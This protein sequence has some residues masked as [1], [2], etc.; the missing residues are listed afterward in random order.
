MAKFRDFEERMERFDEVMSR[1]PMLQPISDI[2]REGRAGRDVRRRRAQRKAQRIGQKAMRMAL[3]V[4]AVLVGSV[5]WGV[6]VGPIGI[7][8]FMAVILA[9]ICLLIALGTYPRDTAPEP[10]KLATA[11]PAVL[12][13]QVDAW[14]DAKRRSL[15][16]LAAPKVDAISAQLAALG[17]QLAAVPAGDPTALELNRLLGKHLPE[18]VDRYEK[19]SPAQR[20][21]ATVPGGPTIERQLVDG[22]GLIEAELVRVNERLGAEDRDAFLVQGK[23]LENRYGKDGTL[24]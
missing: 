15:P 10:V 16:L 23:F 24:S 7:G 9:T 17:P 19:V 2:L 21:V 13:A 11:K 1:I 18:L 22:L 12:P 5:M 6:L 20:K 8:A 14:L 3:T 4:I